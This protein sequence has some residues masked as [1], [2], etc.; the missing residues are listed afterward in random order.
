VPNTWPCPANSPPFLHPHRPHQPLDSDQHSAHPIHVVSEA[1]PDYL[2]PNFASSLLFTSFHPNISSNCAP[3]TIP[4]PWLQTE[5]HSPLHTI[6]PRSRPSPCSSLHCSPHFLRPLHQI[7]SASFFISLVTPAEPRGL[8][9][10]HRL[11]STSLSYLSNKHHHHHHHHPATAPLPI[12]L[13][14]PSTSRLTS[15]NS[16]KNISVLPPLKFCNH[17]RI[18]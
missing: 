16:S 8:S 9:S 7:S 2:H 13:T 14:Q 15:A 18:R 11:S 6:G 4:L 10:S 1:T 12:A 5:T 3:K 17:G